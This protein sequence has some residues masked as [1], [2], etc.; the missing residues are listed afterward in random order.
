MK[1]LY[2]PKTVKKIQEDY[3]FKFSKSLGQNFLVDKNFVDKIVDLADL[4][5]ENVLE[6]GPGIGTISVEIA[7]K[8]KKLVLIEIDKSLIPILN[9]NLKEFTNVKIINADIL[10]VDLKELTDSEFSGEDFKMVSNLPYYITTP[11]IES[12]VDDN[13]SCK[14]MTIMVQKEVAQRIKASEK[15]KDYSSLSIFVKFYGEILADF[16]VPKSVFMPMPKIDSTVLKI[17]LRKYHE[18]VDRKIL[19]SLVRGGF[20]QRRKTILNSF[21]QVLPKDKLK[22]IFEKLSYKENL[23]AE[24]L[25]LD[26]YIRLAEEIEKN[27]RTSIINLN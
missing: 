12:L 6:I 20:N 25:S 23:R 16:K 14:D 21:S 9:E 22:E 11:I 27:Y 8:A 26:D 3:G 10:K 4:Q 15:D 5:G 7:K 24:N 17:R 2:S 13:L 19:F 18:S 1:K